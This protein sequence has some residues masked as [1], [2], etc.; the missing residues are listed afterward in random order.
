MTHYI[1]KNLL[2][3][4]E[5]TTVKKIACNWDINFNCNNNRIVGVLNDFLDDIHYP[6]FCIIEVTIRGQNETLLWAHY[7]VYCIHYSKFHIIL[8][9]NHC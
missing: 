9:I 4:L 2:L 5:V 1:I 8:Q 7:F 3:L 6:E